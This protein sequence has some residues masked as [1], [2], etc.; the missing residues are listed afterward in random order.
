MVDVSVFSWALLVAA[1]TLYGMTQRLQTQGER[2]RI[3]RRNHISERHFSSYL[4]PE[5]RLTPLAARTD[6]VRAMRQEQTGGGR[7][8]L[9]HVVQL[10]ALLRPSVVAVKF[11]SGLVAR[12]I[13]GA[14]FASSS[15]PDPDHGGQGS[16][17]P[18]SSARINVAR[19]AGRV[20]VRGGAHRFGGLRHR[21]SSRS[22]GG[23]TGPGR[24]R[25][26][27]RT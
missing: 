6:S 13:P 26:H 22:V 11:A 5:Q 17:R 16:P 19:Q 1:E 23:S 27:V 10:P 12:Q 25:R 4:R 15:Y 7:G 20:A 9:S 24:V 14:H 2:G 21:R 18:V 3:P 8:W